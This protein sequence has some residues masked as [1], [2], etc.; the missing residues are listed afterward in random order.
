MSDEPNTNIFADEIFAET[1]TATKSVEVEQI[2]SKKVIISGE[3]EAPGL[4]LIHI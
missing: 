4:S 3:I 1:I 2:N